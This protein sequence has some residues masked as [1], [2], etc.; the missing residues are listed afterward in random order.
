[1]QINVARA[2]AV[3]GEWKVCRRALTQAQ[4]A[5]DED[6]T[7]AVDAPV[8]VAG[9]DA[10]KEKGAK[11]DKGKAA[12][13]PIPA[14]TTASATAVKSAGGKRAWNPNEVDAR[15][16]ESLELYREHSKA[17]FRAEIQT[18]EQFV[19]RSKASGAS[20]FE[21]VF[22]Y[23]LRLF[24]F[25]AVPVV[26]GQEDAVPLR[27][28]LVKPV[29]RSVE[30]DF[31]LE[32]FCRRLTGKSCAQLHNYSL[33]GE[34]VPPVAVPTPKKIK[35]NKN[36][37]KKGKDASEAPVVKQEDAAAETG[38]KEAVAKEGAKES[39]ADVQAEAI[40]LKDAKVEEPTAETQRIMSYRPAVAKSLD[41]SGGLLF[42]RI[43][44]SS[45]GNAKKRPV[46]L[47]VCSGAGEWAVAQA[48][49]DNG[50]DWVTLELRSD[51][52]YQTF[53]K[54]IFAGATNLCV[55]CGDA[56]RVLPRHMLAGSISQ[57]FVNHPEPPQQ[58]GGGGGSQSA[59]LLDR[60]FFL[61]ANRLLE[62]G[63]LF[64]IVTDNLWY[65]RML[66][67]LVASISVEGYLLQSED[68]PEAQPSDKAGK[69]SK[70]KQEETGGTAGCDWR[71][72]ESEN[73]VNLFTG[74]PGARAGHVV[75]A[76]SYF[77]RLWK[78]GNLVE[79][80]F[81][82]LRRVDASAHTATRKRALPAFDPANSTLTAGIKNSRIKFE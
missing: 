59:H 81:I 75:D 80:Y 65:G 57:L 52:A 71:L 38:A 50:S 11:G 72:Q 33:T 27:K 55:L 23:F 56:T 77:D 12:T 36:K 41:P 78:R 58:T 69:T 4:A 73:G 64:T 62:P 28:D 26:A 49:E 22:P 54:A 51:R 29:M 39:K 40:E 24:P 42:D 48:R 31:G 30:E 74:T 16:A 82:V 79:R 68:L 60:A 2:A 44:S 47:E 66:M 25:S 63:G 61:Q 9:G 45:S 1:M 53:T 5:L 32:I 67:R 10:K 17:E 6:G 21:L 46:K 3:L 35:K 18:I 7:K 20:A 70:G 19:E 43:F 34:P 13:A 14:T 76:S 8:D 15:R 37:G